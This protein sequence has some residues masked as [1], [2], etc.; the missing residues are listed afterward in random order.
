MLLSNINRV[1]ILFTQ[2]N[3]D[4]NVSAI[5]MDT[6]DFNRDDVRRE[7]KTAYDVQEAELIENYYLLILIIIPIQE[8]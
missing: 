7:V 1:I 2:I 4:G 6:Y 5:I 3:K 8:I